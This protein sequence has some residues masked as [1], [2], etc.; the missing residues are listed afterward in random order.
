MEDV[1]PAG[2]G[3]HAA[4]RDAKLIHGRSVRSPPRHPPVVPMQ[5]RAHATT[6]HAKSLRAHRREAATS[7]VCLDR[8]TGSPP[9]PDGIDFAFAALWVSTRGNRRRSEEHTSEL[10]SLAYLVCRLLLEKKK[11][12]S[13]KTYS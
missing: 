5:S 8:S 1:A 9:R 11:K 2:G 6:A 4:P 3:P 7:S 12:K 10:Q 13:S